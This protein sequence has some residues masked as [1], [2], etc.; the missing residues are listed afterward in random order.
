MNTTSCESL[1]R[2][3]C[4]PPAIAVKRPAL[5]QAVVAAATP[6]QLQ[7]LLTCDTAKT[8]LRRFDDAVE[9][10]RELAVNTLCMLIKV[11]SSPWARDAAS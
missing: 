7:E 2:S 1:V 10:C 6:E 4:P 3:S 9:A 5:A 8:L 11:R